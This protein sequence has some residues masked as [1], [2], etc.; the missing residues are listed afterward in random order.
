MP[1]FLSVSIIL[2]HE[3]KCSVFLTEILSKTNLVCQ[4]EKCVV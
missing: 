3:N 4:A 2:F 1:S